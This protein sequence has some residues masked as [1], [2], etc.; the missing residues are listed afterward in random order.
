MKWITIPKS[1][2]LQEGSRFQ[3]ILLSNRETRPCN[4]WHPNVK[5]DI[6]ASKFSTEMRNVMGK[7][8]KIN[9]NETTIGRLR[10]NHVHKYDS[11]GTSIYVILRRIRGR[12]RNSK[13]GSYRGPGAHCMDIRIEL[14]SKIIA[15]N[16]E[17]SKIHAI[18]FRFRYCSPTFGFDCT[19]RDKGNP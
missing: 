9:S 13:D 16:K 14:W 6:N 8:G 1:N 10:T 11:R 2:D 15:D 19:G 7:S 4:Y 17:Q 3:N 5:R 12:L 18:N